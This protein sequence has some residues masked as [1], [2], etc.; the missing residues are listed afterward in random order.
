MIFYF[1][2]KNRDI[3]DA[4]SMYIILPNNRTGISTL[5]KNFK[6]LT[7]KAFSEGVNRDVH[8]YLPKFTIGCKLDLNYPVIEVIFNTDTIMQI[9][10][11][12]LF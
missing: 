9:L 4:M 1:S 3:S 10:E 6:T 8:L 12:S 11:F 2:L 5:R 7:S